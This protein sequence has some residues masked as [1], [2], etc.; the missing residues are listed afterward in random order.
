VYPQL[1]GTVINEFKGHSDTYIIVI[2]DICEI[3][4]YEYMQTANFVFFCLT[5]YLIWS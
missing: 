5:D 4:A 3:V 1:I 2:Y